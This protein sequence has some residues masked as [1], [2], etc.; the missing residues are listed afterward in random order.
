MESIKFSSII[1]INNVSLGIIHNATG[2]ENV[3]VDDVAVGIVD[4][5]ATGCI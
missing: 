2:I 1:G 5:L 4:N 3:V